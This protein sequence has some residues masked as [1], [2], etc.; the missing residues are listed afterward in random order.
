MCKS[1]PTRR[2]GC[3]EANNMLSPAKKAKKLVVKKMGTVEEAVV[4]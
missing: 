1:I 3:G 2:T 4:S